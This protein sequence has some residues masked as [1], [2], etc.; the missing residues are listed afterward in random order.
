MYEGLYNILLFSLLNTQQKSKV[1][2]YYFPFQHRIIR[3]KNKTW[4]SKFCFNI[5]T[6]VD[7]TKHL[8]NAAALHATQWF[9]SYRSFLDSFHPFMIFQASFG[10][11]TSFLFQSID[12]SI[13]ALNKRTLIFI[14]LQIIMEYWVL[15]GTWL[16]QDFF[17]PRMHQAMTGLLG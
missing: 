13:L 6:N 15:R 8:S 14:E 1:M 10:K 11:L 7:N 3:F 12:Y 9:V 2:L 17:L 16:Q 5:F 4:S